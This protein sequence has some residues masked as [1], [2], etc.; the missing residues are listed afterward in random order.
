MDRPEVENAKETAVDTAFPLLSELFK[1]LEANE[2]T[3]PYANAARAAAWLYLKHVDITDRDLT[4]RTAQGI[5]APP[6][7]DL[8]TAS[9]AYRQALTALDRISDLQ[10]RQKHQ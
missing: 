6:A 2:S 5:G 10:K 1:L 8:R 4:M 7:V 3:K 9:L